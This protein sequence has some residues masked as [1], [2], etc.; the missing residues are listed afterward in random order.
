M[1]ANKFNSSFLSCQKDV[2]TILK[3][4]F[5][6]NESVGNE[7]KKLLII[8]KR[9]CLDDAKYNDEVKKYSFREIYEKGYV[10]L[11]PKINF[12]EHEEVKSYIL[13]TFDNFIPN[14][15]NPQ[16]RDN[17]IHID[18][19]CHTDYW[20]MTNY[21]IRPFVIA[22]LIDGLL[23]NCRLSGIGKLN[24][25][26]CNEIILN[27]ELSGYT[28]AYRAVHGGDDKYIEEE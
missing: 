9:D 22:G 10:S 6:E 28:L 24:F 27:S 26:G 8:N 4:L 20:K 13:I 5:I 7:L 2:E 16:F 21:R 15:T 23:D 25:A 14:A 17:I 1:N 12:G 3:K 11:V 19:I 18:V